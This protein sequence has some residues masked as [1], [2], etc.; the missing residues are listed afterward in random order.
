MHFAKKEKGIIA[1]STRKQKIIVSLTTYPK[2]FDVVH[3][4]LET[5]LN[6]T[7]KPDKII[8]W[9]SQEEV[10][11]HDNIPKHIQK[12]SDRGLEIKIV[13][14]N[15]RS[16]NK[17]IYALKEYSNDLIITVDDDI[18]YP[19]FLVEELYK[20][21]LQYNN[22][23]IAYRCSQIE[24]KNG[25]IV[26]YLSWKSAKDY[27]N[28]SYKLFPTGVGG[29]LYPPGSLNREVFNEALFMELAPTA[30]DIWFK[31]MA[32]LNGTKTIQVFKDSIEFPLIDG[33]QDD[34][35]WKINNGQ[36]QNDIQLKKV[37]DYFD[38]YDYIQKD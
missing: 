25:K 8:L 31:A 17:L 19:N 22:C 13:S 10:S 30:D 20:K 24:M 5:L 2:R 12:L 11:S 34:A 18:F 7:V 36:N 38:L 14:K 29:I 35:L 37:F 27:Q 16:Y 4:T 6:Q 21:Y 1:N 15:L 32:L 33:S 28:P 9:L 23:I 26:P 3:L